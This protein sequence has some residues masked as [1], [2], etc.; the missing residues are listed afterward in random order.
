MDSSTSQIPESTVNKMSPCVKQNRGI[1]VNPAEKTQNIGRRVSFSVD[2]PV[3][4][5]YDAEPKEP[6]AFFNEGWCGRAQEAMNS[7]GFMDFKSKI[8]AKLSAINNPSL[9]SQLDQHTQPGSRY[10][11]RKSPLVEPLSLCPEVNELE[12]NNE[13]MSPNND[14][15]VITT[16]SDTIDSWLGATTDN[17]TI[18]TPI[19]N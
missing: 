5:E 14:S 18:C 19:I 2:P 12:N 7:S 11:Y 13:S 9:M 16:P 8:E 3:V 6:I 10:K 1:L 4:H 17:F 15:P